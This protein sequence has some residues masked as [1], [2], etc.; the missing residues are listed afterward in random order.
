MS[1][2]SRRSLRATGWTSRHWSGQAWALRD[3]HTPASNRTALTP[4][5][6]PERAG[7]SLR[8]VLD[9]DES[10][11]G[12][13]DQA[14]DETRSE[15]ESVT[16]YSAVEVLRRKDFG[17]LTPQELAEVRRLI[18]ELRWKPATRRQRRTRRARKGPLLDPRRALRESLA[19]GG[20]VL[21]IPR[22]TRRRKTRSL[23]LLCDISGS[24]AR[25]TSLLL[26]FLHAVRQGRGAVETFVFGTRLTRVTRQ[27]RVKIPTRRWPRSPARCSIGGGHPDW[28]LLCRLQSPLGSAS[29]GPRRRGGGD[30][31]RVGSRRP[32]RASRELAHLQ[33]ISY[34][35][36]WLNPLLGVAGYQ[37]LTRG[38]R[39]AMPYIDDFLAAHNLASL[40]ALAV[41]L[42]DLEEQRPERSHASAQPGYPV[43]R[44]NVSG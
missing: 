37:P 22:R 36:V 42:S 12:A 3:L 19:N 18:A 41:F 16:T 21:V 20:E 1:R 39:A 25:Y 5:D 30:Q 11:G 44:A 31:R 23:V 2:C 35:L 8:L 7:P 26:R 43:D 13:E 10:A 27:L 33:R 28:R 29:D 40:E 14:V 38:M 34:R 17:D 32:Y 6:A 9:T 4:G 15:R 24:M